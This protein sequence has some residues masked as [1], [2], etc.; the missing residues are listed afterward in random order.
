[1]D[2]QKERFRQLKTNYGVLM[3]N[4]LSLPLRHGY[5]PAS[6]TYQIGTR[7]DPAWMGSEHVSSDYLI[8]TR[9]GKPV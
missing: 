2:G 7:Y 6:P 3:E 9:N 1:M 4:R 5:Q 8:E